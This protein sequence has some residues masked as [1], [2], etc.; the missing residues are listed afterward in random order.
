MPSGGHR[1]SQL[2]F[3]RQDSILGLRRET[4]DKARR[5][6]SKYFYLLAGVDDPQ[7]NEARSTFPAPHSPEDLEQARG[8]TVRWD[9]VLTR[10]RSSF[11]GSEEE[12]GTGIAEECPGNP[13]GGRNSDPR[14]HCE[15]REVSGTGYWGG[16]DGPGNLLRRSFSFTSRLRSRPRPD[17]GKKVASRPAEQTPSGGVGV[18]AG[19]EAVV[20]M[21]QGRALASPLH[22]QAH[23]C[24][25]PHL[26][27]PSSPTGGRRGRDRK[28]DPSGYRKSLGKGIAAWQSRR[29]FSAR[30][31]GRDSGGD[32]V[33]RGESWGGNGRVPRGYPG[34]ALEQYRRRQAQQRSTST[35][36]REGNRG[37]GGGGEKRRGGELQQP[38][39]LTEASLRAQERAMAAAEIVAEAAGAAGVGEGNNNTRARGPYH[40]T[41]LPLRAPAV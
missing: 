17:S 19:P 15:T 18:I 30:A 9:R 16:G 37:G 8:F 13:G 33:G 32:R 11:S 39:G 1:G 14:R 5:T 25:S 10:S 28:G 31:A 23:S 6:S 22:H 36:R 27:T 29:S 20:E 41:L 26:S 24:I 34:A 7:D 35:D 38:L 21:G 12:E 2:Q 40:R 4:L 3:Q